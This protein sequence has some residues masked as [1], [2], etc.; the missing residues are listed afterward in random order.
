MESAGEGSVGAVVV[1]LADGTVALVGA[2]AESRPPISGVPPTSTREERLAGVGGVAFA[3]AV[4][5]VTCPSCWPRIAEPLSGGPLVGLNN[6]PLVA[7]LVTLCIA[8][9][10]R[11]ESTAVRVSSTRLRAPVSDPGLLPTITG[12]AEA[13]FD[14]VVEA[15]VPATA[16]FA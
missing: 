4:V 1:V 15:I 7:A 6:P 5:G 2:P 11:L 9:E 13:P 14:A 8:R 16:A 12:E 10:V 3:G